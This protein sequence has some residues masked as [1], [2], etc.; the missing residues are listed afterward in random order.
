[1]QQ[2]LVLS[3]SRNWFNYRHTSNTLA[4]HDFLVSEGKYPEER[5]TSMYAQ[6]H[7]CDC[8]NSLPG[9]HYIGLSASSESLPI[10]QIH[11]S[12]ESV[13]DSSLMSYLEM[14]NH[15]FLPRRFR[16]EI[17]E[18]GK[19]FFYFTGHS[20]VEMMKFQDFFE[21]T[22]LSSSMQK[23]LQ[24][25][26]EILMVT[27][28]CKAVTL[29][30]QVEDV[31]FHALASSDISEMSY[32]YMK[33]HDLHQIL[34]DRFTYFS[35]KYLKSIF[36]KKKTIKLKEWRDA[37]NGTKKLMSTATIASE[38]KSGNLDV[39]KWLKYKRTVKKLEKAPIRNKVG[40]NSSNEN[41][42]SW[43]TEVPKDLGKTTNEGVE[44]WWHSLLA[45]WVTCGL[46]GG[47][48]FG[49]FLV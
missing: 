15:P 14:K 39:K 36:G 48:I 43:I 40:R 16:L 47:L 33:D 45:R 42:L 46:G 6:T 34:A 12:G 29:P 18:G 35:I 30:R 27:D 5:I 9:S 49:Y 38:E 32:G 44:R 1:M 31:E 41:R 3:S 7:R 25:K 8:R 24:K 28:T 21:L 37:V 22:D 4:F 26:V 19:F 11:F 13:T 17:P 23:L 10:R 20:N 2:A